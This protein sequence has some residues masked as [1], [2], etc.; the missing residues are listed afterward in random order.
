MELEKQQRLYDT[1]QK[2][3]PKGKFGGLGS[4]GLGAA[5][6]KRSDSL[7][8]NP[9]YANFI[10]A[11]TGHKRKFDEDGDADDGEGRSKEEPAAKKKN[12]KADKVKA[13][14]KE[15]ETSGG[16]GSEELENHKMFILNLL[17]SA[18]KK[19]MK[20]KKVRKE[21]AK[22]VPSLDKGEVKVLTAGLVNSMVDSKEV[23]ITGDDEIRLLPQEKAKKEKKG[24]KEKKE[25]EVDFA[26]FQNMIHGILTEAAGEPVSVKALRKQCSKKITGLDK[27]ET[28]IF[29][30]GIANKMVDE[31]V[32]EILDEEELRLI[33]P[34]KERKEKKN[35]K[36]KKL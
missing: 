21:I 30:A 2:L 15:E 10:R 7:P 11:G 23:E 24:K 4:S 26:A 33:P 8:D 20:H 31:G 18:D 28:K 32:V 3:A 6:K 16:D 1:L 35:K 36:D 9:L 29:V 14:A 27:E 34:K 12:K 22:R 13:K 17:T 25:K 19:T 5:T